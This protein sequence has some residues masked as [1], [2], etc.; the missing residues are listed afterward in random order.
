M[1]CVHH[2]IALDIPVLHTLLTLLVVC[3]LDRMTKSP[4]PRG[5]AESGSPLRQNFGEQLKMWNESGLHDREF[6]GHE[7]SREDKMTSLA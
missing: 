6:D 1:Q 2:P 4:R 7:V 5:T 3:Q